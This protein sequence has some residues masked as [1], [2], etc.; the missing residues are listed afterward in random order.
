MSTNTMIKGRER[1]DA[2]IH[3]PNHHNHKHVDMVD[4]EPL[5]EIEEDHH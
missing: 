4:D 3:T 5:V 1:F 2:S